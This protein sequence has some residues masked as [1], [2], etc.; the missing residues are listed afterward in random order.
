MAH[1]VIHGTSQVVPGEGESL[2]DVL[3]AFVT[4]LAF[5]ILLGTSIA[6]AVGSLLAAIVAA[7]GGAA[8]GW[9][10][11]R[12]SLGSGER[13]MKLPLLA[14]FVVGM[15]IGG[16][17][18]E[19]ARD[20]GLIGMSAPAGKARRWSDAAGI[21]DTTVGRRLLQRELGQTADPIK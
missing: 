3:L 14:S 11:A 2:R 20:R 17:S 16:V 4:G 5:A 9:A 13:A 8:L 21:P 10:M 6:S 15:A 18:T 12:R 7:L 1:G 19:V